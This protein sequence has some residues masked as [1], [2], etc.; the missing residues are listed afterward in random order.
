MTFALTYNSRETGLKKNFF[1]V[2]LQTT[3]LTIL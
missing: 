2:F 1:Q 3:V